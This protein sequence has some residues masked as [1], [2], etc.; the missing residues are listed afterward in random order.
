LQWI[1]VACPFAF[2]VLC[3]ASA[4]FQAWNLPPY[5]G[6]DELAHA[7]RGNQATFGQ[8][9]AER[10]HKRMIIAG[11]A[12]DMSL[13]EAMVPFDHIRFHLATKADLADYQAA[14]AIR[15]DG[16]TTRA[17]YPG[18]AI[19]PPF[20]YLPQSAGFALGK[21]L[22]WPVVQSLYAARAANA[23]TCALIG[24]AALMIVGRARLLMFSLLLLPMSVALYSTL[25]NDG[26]LIVTTALGCAV[27]CRAMHEGRPLQRMEVVAAAV[28]FA[29]VGMTKLPYALLGLIFLACS[30]ERPRWRYAAC[31][32]VFGLSAAWTAWMALAVQTSITSPGLNVDAGDQLRWLAAHPMAL[33]SVAGQTLKNNFDPYVHMFI[34]VLGWLDAGL[35]ESYHRV[36]WPVLGLALA[37][38]L[39]RGRNAAWRWAPLLA[40]VILVALFG[41]IHAALYL[42]WNEVGAS[43]VQGVQG[44]Y[45]LPLAILGCLLVEGERPLL[46]RGRASELAYQAAAAV[47]LAFPLIS[48]LVVQRTIILRYY[49]D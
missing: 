19:Y 15:W 48:L 41:A 33:F 18:S 49:L 46:P 23:L 31:A 2:L 27:I 1:R 8:L 24:F 10:V 20:F 13:Y 26:L 14:G 42:T 35:P 45:F 44:R 38:S 43:Y 4:L 3:L 6:A 39:S 9:I 21:L 32:A 5:M 16:R 25:T 22:D 40:A 11:G 30:T 37:A 12:T 17:G 7:Y 36:A 28:C 34:G 47:V 29:L